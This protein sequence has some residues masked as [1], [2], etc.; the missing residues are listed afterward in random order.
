MMQIFLAETH[1]DCFF[2][3]QYSTFIQTCHCRASLTSFH[4]SQGNSSERALLIGRWLP[5]VTWWSRLVR[6]YFHVDHLCL[7]DYKET[8]Y[9]TCVRKQRRGNTDCIFFCAYCHC[10]RVILCIPAVCFK[11]VVCNHFSRFVFHV[12]RNTVMC[13][14]CC[15]AKLC[16][17]TILGTFF[18]R[19]VIY[20]LRNHVSASVKSCLLRARQCARQAVRAI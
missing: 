11:C 20:A 4:G 6:Y 8:R 10:F 5:R 13:I 16:I 9:R 1:R 19:Y 12:K 7:Y 2:P 14:E 15:E 3:R 18:T 17:A